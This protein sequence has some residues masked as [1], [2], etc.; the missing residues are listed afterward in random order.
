MVARANNEFRGVGKT[1]GWT[2]F[3]LTMLIVGPPVLFVV[4]YMIRYVTPAT[5]NSVDVPLPSVHG[6][7]EFR[8][9][10]TH[11]YFSEHIYNAQV[12]PFYTSNY[13]SRL[14]PQS[15]S[16]TQMLVSWRRS[17][18]GNGPYLL[19]AEGAYYTGINLR[20]RC[21][22]HGY[23]GE[24]PITGNE[25]HYTD[26]PPTGFAT[27]FWFDLGRIDAP[28]GRLRFVAADRRPDIESLWKPYA[29]WEMP[30]PGTRWQFS[31]E[32]I[33]DEEDAPPRSYWIDLTS[34][35][36]RTIYTRIKSGA[37]QSDIATFYLHKAKFTGGPYLQI[38]LYDD[39]ETS[40]KRPATLIDLG[41]AKVYE[42]YGSHLVDRRYVDGS[43]S[44]DVGPDDK[45]TVNF[46]GRRLPAEPAPASVISRSGREIGRLRFADLEFV[47]TDE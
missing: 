27:G 42:L 6:T 8:R 20:K 46:F 21:F 38:D 24:S 34:G 31:I 13:S 9:L 10:S 41:Q 25:C 4:V 30:L 36:D 32:G 43:A 47:P 12:Q 33:P 39:N 45:N 16:R 11:P 40:A 29:T 19:L 37:Q 17:H 26:K 7:L 28:D 18:G 15:T 14:A 35:Y 3:G 2:L 5:W 23:P 44:S 1:I 22:W